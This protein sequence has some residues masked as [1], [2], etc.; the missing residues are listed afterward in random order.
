[1]TQPNL[2]RRLLLPAFAVVL[3]ALSACSRGGEA[4]PTGAPS[5][6]GAKP[7][8]TA[9]AAPSRDEI[10]CSNIE[11]AFNAWDSSINTP[12]AGADVV[13][14][15]EVHTGWAMEE[16][17]KLLDAIE[18]YENQ[19]AKDLAVKV[20][21]YN[22]ELSLA[23]V[24]ATMSGAIEV[25]QANKVGGAATQVRSSYSAFNRGVCGGS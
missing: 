3:F 19:L 1:M 10:M 8:T 13:A 25:D 2:R 9:A 18:G 4:A 7:A 16:G 21:E 6:T 5:T 15:T 23:N 14:M 24:Q 22:S 11:R 20:A 12:G 17:G